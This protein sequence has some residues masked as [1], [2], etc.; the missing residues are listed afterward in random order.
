MAYTLANNNLQVCIFFKPGED[1]F[2]HQKVDAF[3]K[4]VNL[5]VVK[6]DV[7]GWVKANAPDVIFVY[8]YPDLLDVT[9]FKQPVY[10]I[11][12]GP[13]PSYRGPAPVFWQLK[14]GVKELCVSIHVLTER[15]DAGK[16]VWEKWIPDQGHYNYGLVQQLFSQVVIGGV[17]A[18]LNGQVMQVNG[19]VKG[20]YDKRPVLADVLIRW[21]EMHAKEICDLVRACNPWN[22]GAVTVFNGEEVK[23]MDAVV[24]GE[25]GAAAGMIGENGGIAT[26]D[27]QLLRVNMFFM[28]EVFVPGYL[29]GLHGLV[30][31]QKFG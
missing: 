8:G 31:G 28:H 24:V 3:A 7:Y 23:V 4:A 30:K 12:P 13:L 22:K 10:N 9:Q 2:A 16:V 1:L 5:P 14:R 18:I 29:G 6:V 15:F 19:V 17:M 25:T 27:G 26:V 11:H 20:G 21:Q